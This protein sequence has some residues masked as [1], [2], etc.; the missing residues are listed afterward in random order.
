MRQEQ[1]TVMAMKIIGTRVQQEA[2]VLPTYQMGGTTG[3]TIRSLKKPKKHGGYFR[4]AMVSVSLG[5][6]FGLFAG[7]GF[8]AVHREPGCL[9]PARYRSG[10]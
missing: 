2:T 7:I 10:R 9:R 1:K 5:L 4:K 8:Y 6:F 3:T